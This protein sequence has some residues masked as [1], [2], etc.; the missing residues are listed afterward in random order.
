MKLARVSRSL[1][2][3]VAAVEDFSAASS[4][5]PAGINSAMIHLE[6]DPANLLGEIIRQRVAVFDAAAGDEAKQQEIQ[7]RCAR[8]PIYFINNWVWTYDPRRKPSTMPFCMFARQED[9]IRW[10]LDRV[11]ASE[12]GIVEKSRDAGLSWLCIAFSAWQFLYVPGSKVTFG[13]RKGDLVDTLGNPDSLFEKFRILLKNLPEWMRPLNYS[14]NEL[15]FVNR[16]N[17]A[18]VTGEAGDQ[19]GRGG[20][21]TLYFLDE[22]AFVERANK[23][24]AAVSDNSDVKLYVSTPNGNG[25]AFAKKRHSG[26]FPVFQI[27]WLDDPRKNGWVIRGEDGEILERGVGRGAPSNAVYP[28][29]ERKCKTLDPVIRAQEVDIDYNASIDGICIPYDWIRSAVMLPLPEIGAKNAGM[30]VADGGK[31]KTVFIHRSGP[32][33]REEW[34]H[35]WSEGN[36]TQT[37]FKA[38]Q[39]GER[40][41]IDRLYFDGIGVG[42]GVGGTLKSTEEIQ[43]RHTAINSQARA[44]DVEWVEFGK[45][46]GPDIFANIRAELWWRLRRRFERTYEHVTGVAVHPLC[47]LIS[48]PNHPELISQLG[49]PLRK[50]T[51]T[52]RILIESK[53]DMKTRGVDSPDFADALAFAFADIPDKTGVP[54]WLKK[55]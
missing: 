45:R 15:R 38:R 6:K 48:I 41:G 13:S 49:Q 1:E 23:V 19:M 27:H 10:L 18:S 47:D 5:Y 40:Y 9:F 4:R 26:N 22:F 21:S 2:I 51:S 42:A 3:A 34:I 7:E 12:D 54:D 32:V 31:D 50:F 39:L 14:D 28:W 53:D 52:G 17:G 35:S 43:F 24:D 37:A 55:Y 25:N 11:D 33:V 8:D 29:Y 36:T 16:E 44:T 46:S 20:R 30:D